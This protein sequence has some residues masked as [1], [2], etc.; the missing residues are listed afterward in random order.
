MLVREGTKCGADKVCIKQVCEKAS[1]LK[2]DCDPIRKC[3]GHGLCN[4][5]KNCHCDRGWSPP[6]C[7]TKGSPMGGSV[8]SGLR[9]LSPE[10]SERAAEDNMR[11]WVLLSIFLFLPVIILLAILLIKWKRISDYCTEFDGSEG[12][13]E[14][15][16]RSDIS[17]CLAN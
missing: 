10:L 9:I 11:T 5:K 2:Y 14:S 8:D 6:N 4:N 15:Y 16:S 1:I 3:S 12:E 17:R 13:T 7:K